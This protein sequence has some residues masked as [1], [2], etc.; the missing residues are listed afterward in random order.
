MSYSY[1]AW[2]STTLSCIAAQKV[3]LEKDRLYTIVYPD[4]IFYIF[5]RPAV[6][7]SLIEAPWVQSTGFDSQ[8]VYLRT[9][10]GVFVTSFRSLA[11][12]WNHLNPNCF[13]Q[14]YRSL[15][16][17]RQKMAEIDDTEAKRKRVR[18]ALS[19]GTKEWLTVSRRSFQTLRR[20]TGLRF[21]TP[22]REDGEDV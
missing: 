6:A 8:Y 20:Q 17:N 10:T 21:R 7:D 14:L 18:V 9:S 22:M 15:W 4:A 2:F 13:F 12:L 11:Q 3:G 19:A 5:S 1:A 16:I